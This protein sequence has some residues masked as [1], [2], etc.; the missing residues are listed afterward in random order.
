MV[1]TAL[2]RNK[3]Q[4]SGLKV[5]HIAQRSGILRETLYNKLNSKSE[6][7]VS[8]IVSLTKVLPLTKQER[9]EIFTP[10]LV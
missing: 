5:N 2:L 1:N 6:F 4:E 10:W 8:G 9:D 7:A 3:I